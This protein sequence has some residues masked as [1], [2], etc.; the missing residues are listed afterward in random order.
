MKIENN[1]VRNE[2]GLTKSDMRFCWI[3]LAI[4]AAFVAVGW[5]WTA[6]RL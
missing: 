6:V 2:I 4:V 1:D 5:I 3:T